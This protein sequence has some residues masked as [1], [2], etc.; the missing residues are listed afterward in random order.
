MK[1]FTIEG[2]EVSN[3]I[4]PVQKTLSNGVVINTVSVGE[5]GRGRK[6]S[7]LVIDSDQQTTHTRVGKTQ[8]GNNRLFKTT[9][10]SDKE[11]LVVLR[12]GIGFRGGNRH[13]IPEGVNILAEGQ[14]AQGAAG[15][16]G[17]G[18]QYILVLPK[19]LEIK[20]T[21]TGRLYGKPDTYHL[22]FDGENLSYLTSL[23]KD[24]LDN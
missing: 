2:N 13:E 18:K 24:L 4:S 1:A 16:M 20:V 9:E 11:C 8:N 6:K 12:T 21:L 23:E 22:T 19:G 7:Y 10:D 15:N 14:I 17:W 5:D 3:F